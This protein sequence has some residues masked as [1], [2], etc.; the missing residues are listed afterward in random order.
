M[1]CFIVGR[2]RLWRD[3]LEHYARSGDVFWC[4]ADRFRGDPS[5][6]AEMD[7][8]KDHRSLYTSYEMDLRL[9]RCMYEGENHTLR[10]RLRSLAPDTPYLED[11]L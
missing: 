5:F 1:K 3:S 10:H 6:L 9:Q 2:P 7:D 4:A 8:P 11:A